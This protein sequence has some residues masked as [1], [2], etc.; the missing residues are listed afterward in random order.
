MKVESAEEAEAPKLFYANGDKLQ[1]AKKLSEEKGGS[2]KSWYE[3]LGGA[4]L[5]GHGIEPVE[6]E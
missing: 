4:F 3:I 5:D 6:E 1:R 2:I